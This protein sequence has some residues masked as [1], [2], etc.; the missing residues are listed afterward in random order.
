MVS[1]KK[2]RSSTAD[3]SDKKPLATSKSN[4]GRLTITRNV[5]P[6]LPPIQ[7]PESV[8]TTEI[9]LESLPPKTPAVGDILSPPSTEPSTSR[10]ETKDTPP[11]GDLSSS[12]QTG[13]GARPSRRARPQVSYKEPSLSVKMRRPGKELVDA[14]PTTHGKRTS[15]E[16]PPTIKREPNDA[17]LALNS[18]PLTTH[19]GAD[20]DGEAGSPLREKLGRKEGSQNSENGSEPLKLNS[21]AASNAIS[22]LISATGTTK[23]K[24]SGSSTSSATNGT[25]VV[26]TAKSSTVK[27]EENVKDNLAAFDFTDS[28]PNHPR[29]DLAKVAKNRRHSSVPASSA[30]EER[31]SD[32]KTKSSGTLPSLHSRSGSG[33]GVKNVSTSSLARSTSSSSTKSTSVKEKKVAALPT[34]GSNIDLK[35]VAEASETGSLRAERAASRRKSMML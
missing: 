17:N 15:T 6:E 29:V 23:R 16:P 35:A 10:P 24:T 9:H 1:P 27:E 3:K 22:A 4:R 30:T 26:S 25:G 18:V 33:A 32:L 21:S 12:D 19:R 34:S 31:K 2:Q 28:S 11:P 7:V 5:Q 14:V 20:E 8:P 13:Q